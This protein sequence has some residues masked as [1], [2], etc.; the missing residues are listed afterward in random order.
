MQIPRL[1]TLSKFKF[2]SKKKKIW[3]L[4]QTFFF[5]LKIRKLVTALLEN[6]YCYFAVLEIHLH[7]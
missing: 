7:H 3:A 6:V 1:T 5:L 2:L 4:R